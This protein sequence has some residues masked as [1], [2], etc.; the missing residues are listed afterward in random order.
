MIDKIQIRQMNQMHR[1]GAM[2]VLLDKFV[3]IL[4]SELGFTG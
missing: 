4:L 3:P 1:P 2:D